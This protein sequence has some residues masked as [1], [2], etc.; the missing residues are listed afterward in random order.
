MH[1]VNRHQGFFSRSTPNQP[2]FS[3]KLK[4]KKIGL[5]SPSNEEGAFSVSIK[6]PLKTGKFEMEM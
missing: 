6:G 2:F 1:S 5:F 4:T 3:N